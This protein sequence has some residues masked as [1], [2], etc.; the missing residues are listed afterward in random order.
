MIGLELKPFIENI[1]QPEK[2][3]TKHIDFSKREKQIIELLSLG[4]NSPQMAATMEISESTVRVQLH[5]IYV[6]SGVSTKKEFIELLSEYNS[7]SEQP[8]SITQV[9]LSRVFSS[10]LEI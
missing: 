9:L 4:F 8:Y 2:L 10:D 3:I 5:N 1:I 7:K 6:K